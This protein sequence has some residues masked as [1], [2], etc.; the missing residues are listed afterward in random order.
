MYIHPQTAQ[1]LQCL[2]LEGNWPDILL[3]SIMLCNII[4]YE[5]WRKCP[6][7]THTPCVSLQWCLPQRSQAQ[8]L[9]TGQCAGRRD[10]CV[11][12]FFHGN[13]SGQTINWFKSWHH[14]KKTI[15]NYEKMVHTACP[16]VSHPLE[17]LL[18]DSHTPNCRLELKSGWDLS[19]RRA[20]AKGRPFQF[21]PAGVASGM[22]LKCSVRHPSQ[23]L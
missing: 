1:H 8:T 4:G 15:R 22:P 3:H 19:G 18:Q 23:L 13:Q 10:C 7:S 9:P 21:P 14:L 11:R 2:P 12:N 16:Q 20:R 6:Y 5:V 17:Q